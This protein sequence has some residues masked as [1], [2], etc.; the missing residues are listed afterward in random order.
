M[1]GLQQ[2]IQAHPRR[3]LLPVYFTWRTLISHGGKAPLS[4]TLA[5]PRI[6][7]DM[8]SNSRSE[9]AGGGLLVADRD[10]SGGSRSDS[11]LPSPSEG[12]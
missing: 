9:T 6:V 5:G 2:N 4:K 7:D 12:N 11:G 10:R 1:A 8:P 3:V